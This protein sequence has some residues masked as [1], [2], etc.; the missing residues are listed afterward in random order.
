MQVEN[1]LKKLYEASIEAANPAAMVAA[2]ANNILSTHA[3]F[4]F[5]RTVLV[6]A[7]KAAPAMAEALLQSTGGIVDR[8]LVITKHGYM[9]GYDF[10]FYKK[11]ETMEAG[12][13]IPDENSL[14][15]GAKALALVREEQAEDT[16][17]IMLISGGGSSL[18]C[19]PAGE[20]K[21]EEK[22]EVFDKLL[23][24]G[25][26]ISEMNTVRK[27]L[28]ALKGGMLMQEAGQ[29]KVISLIVSDVPGDDVSLIASGP[30]VADP[31]TATDAL[32]VLTKYAITPPATVLAHL[33]SVQRG[34]TPDT[35][36]E[37][38][39]VFE[40]TENLVIL[41]NHTALEGALNRAH[42]FSLNAV[43][44]DDPVTGDVGQAA[45]L[46]AA[47]AAAKLKSDNLPIC[48]ISGGE[49]TVKVTGD[50]KGGRNMELALRFA[51]ELEGLAGITMLSAGTDGIDGPTDAAGA[52]VSTS[53]VPGARNKGIEPE[54][55]LRQNNSY[56]FFKDTGGLFIT[57]PTGTNVMDIQFIIVGA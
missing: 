51:M 44:L 50:G 54:F 20:I 5:R 14:Q 42:A 1:L 41:N 25:A 46:L 34:L 11:I 40:R 53:T 32:A 24:C 26:D 3:H 36:D 9:E 13:P 8:G 43:I 37:D 29:S 15:A 10:S 22:Q 57:G 38:S 30:T 18:M 55:Y 23:T 45:L 12:H 19:A 21:F 33:L 56:N 39:T 35:P 52:I 2:C 49:T 4:G 48:L 16:L 17:I 47:K 27:H 6:A 7:G 31:S 28:S